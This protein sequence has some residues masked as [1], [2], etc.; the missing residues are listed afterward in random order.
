MRDDDTL[1][2]DLSDGSP[3]QSV[4]DQSREIHAAIPDDA[5]TAPYGKIDPRDLGEEPTKEIPVESFADTGARC[6][7]ER[8]EMEEKIA[9]AERLMKSTRPTVNIRPLKK[10]MTTE[11]GR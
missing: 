9:E 10:R 6:I 8:R 1:V 11:V 7:A 5:P 4:V 2:E 3:N